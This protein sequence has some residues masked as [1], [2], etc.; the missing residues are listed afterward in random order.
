MS[1]YFTLS[2][3]QARA[4]MSLL[5]LHGSLQITQVRQHNHTYRITCQNQT[6]YLKLH[7]K[8]WYPPDEGQK[9]FSVRHEISAWKIL[10]RH[11]LATPDVVLAGLNHENPLGHAYF[12]TRE[13]PGSLLADVLDKA[14]P[15]EIAQILHIV[16]LYLRR[17]HTIEFAYPGYLLGE[18]P[19]AAPDRDSWQHFTWT[20][21]AR[22]QSMHQWIHGHQDELTSFLLAQLEEMV[23][24]VPEV[25]ASAYTS[26][27]FTQGDCGIDQIMMAQQNGSW[28]VS[29]FLDMEVASAGDSISDLMSLCECLAQIL[30]STLHWWESLFEG[31]GQEPDFAGFR[32]RLLG[33]WY[34]Y[35][36]HIWPGIGENGFIHL[37]QAKDWETLF[38]H[39]HLP[40]QERESISPAL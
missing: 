22:Q 10:A 20:L 13:V 31:Y 28:S 25:L 27:R 6:F 2:D 37:L 17:M 8:D 18:G 14:S 24:Q 35:Q 38:S 36:A 34:P 3:Q 1:E 11:A 40:L 33:G 29:A 30:P 26:P 9:G 19:T 15:Q 12:L 39:A 4:L 32:L 21:Q 5:D 16:G 7:T 23:Q